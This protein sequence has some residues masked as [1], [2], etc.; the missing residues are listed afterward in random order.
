MVN[1]S[2]LIMICSQKST[3]LSSPPKAIGPRLLETSL[4]K[5]MRENTWIPKEYPLYRIIYRK[6][7]V[8]FYLEVKTKQTKQNKTKKTIKKKEKERKTERGGGENWICFQKHN[9]P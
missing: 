7:S 5:G 9:Y 3:E 4:L 8:L 1:P 6:E 2:D